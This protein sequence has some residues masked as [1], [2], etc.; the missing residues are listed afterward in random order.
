[1]KSLR[2]FGES[3]TNTSGNIIIA[4]TKLS[5]TFAA[6]RLSIRR[7]SWIDGNNRP[8]TFVTSMRQ[9]VPFNKCVLGWHKPVAWLRRPQHD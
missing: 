9:A 2:R 5:K 3:A 1:M 7:E 4:W 8:E 6:G